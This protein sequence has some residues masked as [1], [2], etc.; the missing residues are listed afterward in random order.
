MLLISQEKYAFD[1][2]A[3][4]GLKDANGCTTP[5]KTKVDSSIGEQD[6]SLDDM[7]KQRYQAAIGSLI[8]LMLGSRPDLAYAINKLAQY[9]SMHMEKHWKAVKRILRFV[10]YT[11]Y[12]S[13]ILGKRSDKDPLVGY[14]D[15]AYMNDTTDRHSTM[16]YMFFYHG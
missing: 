9:S 12:T 4:F 2:V 8:Y 10:K 5:I 13:L 3:R 15:A 6:V 7:G 1:I 11:S 14:F 16:G